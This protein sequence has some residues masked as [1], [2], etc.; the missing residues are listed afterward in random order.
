MTRS[1]PQARGL[2]ALAVATVAVVGVHVWLD[3]L[4]VVEAERKTVIEADGPVA[5]AGQELSLTGARWDEF[6]VADGSRSLSIRMRSSGGAD[7]TMCGL[8]VLREPGGGRSW[9]D[10]DDL[11]DVPYDEGEPSCIAESAPYEILAVFLV[12]DD[13]DGPFVLD[14]PGEGDVVARFDIE[15]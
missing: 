1:R 3:V 11:I 13:A 9:L 12:P 8:F 5:V 6:E 10:A 14:V 2:I 15:P 4:P 7:A